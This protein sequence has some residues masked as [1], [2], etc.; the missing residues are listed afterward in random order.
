MCVKAIA[1]DL[2]G[3]HEPTRPNIS[4]QVDSG[5]S[6]PTPSSP[7]GAFT[8]PLNDDLDA[9]NGDGGH[10]SSDDD[11]SSPGERHDASRDLDGN[12]QGTNCFTCPVCEK[13]FP[14]AKR[15]YFL[16]AGRN[17]GRCLGSRQM[18]SSELSRLQWQRLSHQGLLECKNCS[19]WVHDIGRHPNLQGNLRVQVPPAPACGCTRTRRIFRSEIPRVRTGAGAYG[20]G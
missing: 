10:L 15:Q 9:G 3:I 6:S 14:F 16:N 2:L 7:D 1:A 17:V 18:A 13:D 5:N 12:G 20:C 11:L 4:R 8:G 19:V